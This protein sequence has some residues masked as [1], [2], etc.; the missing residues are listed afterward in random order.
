MYTGSESGSQKDKAVKSFVNGDT[1]L[2]F[3]SLCSG[4]GLDGIQKRCSVAVF[5]ELDWSPGIHH[6]LIGRLDREGQQKQ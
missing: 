6:Q 4:V 2:M 3:I 1:N 5:E